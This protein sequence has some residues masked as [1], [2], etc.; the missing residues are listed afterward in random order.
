M[1]KPPALP[2]LRETLVQ[3]AGSPVA[4]ALPD[5]GVRELVRQHRRKRPLG[6]VPRL[7]THADLAVEDSR[8]PIRNR[9]QRKIGAPRV[10]DDDLE[11]RELRP[12]EGRLPEVCRLEILAR[13]AN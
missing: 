8:D 3:P 7:D 13:E 2:P 5:Q 12:E 9:E 11:P 1:G 4:R 10:E 6:A